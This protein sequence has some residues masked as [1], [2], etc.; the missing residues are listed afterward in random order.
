MRISIVAALSAVA[1]WAG[2]GGANAEPSSSTCRLMQPDA[3][4]STSQECA[5]CHAKRDEHPVDV[6]YAGVQAGRKDLRPIA[7]VVK[8]GLFMPEG[9]VRCVTCHDGRSQWKFRIVLP[10]G[11]T[12]TPLTDPRDENAV[13]PA[14][15]PG[16]AVA[17]KPLCLAC[18]MLD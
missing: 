6:D 17:P 2:R 4:L 15:G 1:I 3:A 9:A 13:A 8:R 14:L 10:P 7:E 11:S 18:H 5:A 12:P 16:S